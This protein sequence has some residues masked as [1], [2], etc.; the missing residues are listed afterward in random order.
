MFT[1]E[2]R[3]ISNL[4]GSCIIEDRFGKR[5]ARLSDRTVRDGITQSKLTTIEH[6]VSDVNTSLEALGLDIC[7]VIERYV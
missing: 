1:C 3:D 2:P 5:C 4:E 6:A 7:L